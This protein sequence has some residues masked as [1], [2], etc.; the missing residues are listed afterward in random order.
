M[1]LAPLVSLSVPKLDRLLFIGNSFTGVNNLPGL[2]KSLLESDRSGR[3]VTV[4]YMPAEHLNDVASDPAV[5]AEIEKGRWDIVLLEGALVSMSHKFTYPQDGGIALGKAARAAGSRALYWV[6]WPR[7][8][9]DESVYTYNI[10]ESI[11]RSAKAELAPICYVWDETARALP[12]PDLWDRD[13]NHATIYGSYVASC[14]LYYF[15][16]DGAGTNPTWAPSELPPG[17]AVRYR[18][19]A[20]RVIQE[21]LHPPRNRPSKGR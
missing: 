8:G 17:L 14:G 18:E 2:V 11:R 3:K 19:I 13:G 21:R 9:I 1:I 6:E 5:L 15:L 12:A 10:Y 7:K 16:T 4:K 20:R